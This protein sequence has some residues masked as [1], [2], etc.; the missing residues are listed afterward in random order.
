MV[1]LSCA[2]IF[3]CWCYMVTEWQLGC[4]WFVLYLLT[5]TVLD[6]W[7]WSKQGHSS[8]FHDSHISERL[9]ALRIYLWT[10]TSVYNSMFLHISCSFQHLNYCNPIILFAMEILAVFVTWDT[11]VASHITNLCM[12]IFLG[13]EHVKAFKVLVTCG[14][15][16]PSH[17]ASWN[18]CLYREHT[19]C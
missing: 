14:T 5:I 10:A 6:S 2:L 16:V 11:S 12:Y 7:S 3:P 18:I 13:D 9:L 17:I 15:S 4:V 8:L 19:T 1:I